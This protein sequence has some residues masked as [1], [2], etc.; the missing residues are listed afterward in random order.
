MS[1]HESVK[2]H[3][4]ALDETDQI[5]ISSI[6]RGEIRYGLERM[7]AGKR[8]SK[9]KEKTDKL[10]LVI[11]RVTVTEEVADKYGQVKRE[12]E[13]QGTYLSD[14]D[15]WIAATALA[16]D[17]ILVSNDSDFIRISK[18]IIENWVE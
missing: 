10:F 4:E 11:P 7:P 18:L 15:L 16:N 9:L 12:A 3:I 8:R 2:A 5:V 6:V 17:A 14:N 13:K 1:E